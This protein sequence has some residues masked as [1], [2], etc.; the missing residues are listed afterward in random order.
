MIR[1]SS[2]DGDGLGLASFKESSELEFGADD[3]FMLTTANE[4]GEMVLK[5]LKARHS[6][7]RDLRVAG[8]I[9]TRASCI[10]NPLPIDPLAAGDLKALRQ[11]DR[12]WTG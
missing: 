12:L 3:A 5:H 6:Q 4:S 1:R 7:P 8:L 10:A 11:A 2:C 9:S